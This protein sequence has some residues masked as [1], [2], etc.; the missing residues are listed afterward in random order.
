M[1]NTT[2]YST[3]DP[4]RRGEIYPLKEAMRR[5]CWGRA[6]YRTATQNGLKTIHTSGRVFISGDALSD[7]L[8]SLEGSK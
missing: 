4:I 8:T 7:Y 5:C 3:A 2:A 1:A 6:A